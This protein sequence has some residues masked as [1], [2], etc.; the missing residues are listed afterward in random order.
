MQILTLGLNHHT[1]PLSLREKVSFSADTLRE[2][3]LDLRGRLNRLLPE[4]AIL[5]TCNRLELY[6]VAH[7]PTFDGLLDFLSETSGQPRGMF[8]PF[9]ARRVDDHNTGRSKWTS[10]YGPWELVWQRGPMSMTE[11]RKLENRLK[12]QRGWRGFFALTGLRPVMGA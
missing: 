8:E 4:S 10:R 5:S 9:V 2:A 6:A 3:L 12:R 11:A 1:A 7:T